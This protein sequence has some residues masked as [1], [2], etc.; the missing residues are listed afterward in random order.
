MARVVNKLTDP[1]VGKRRP[2]FK[3]IFFIKAR[4]Q[5]INIISVLLPVQIGYYTGELGC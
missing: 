4:S 1:K 2:C 5:G 3:R